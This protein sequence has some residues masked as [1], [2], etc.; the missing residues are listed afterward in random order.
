MLARRV[1]AQ[2]SASTGEWYTPPE[3]IELVREALGGID[4]DPCSSARANTIVKATAIYTAAD[5]PLEVPWHNAHR[6]AFVNP[7]GTCSPGLLFYSGCGNLIITKGGG[8]GRCSCAL[9][10]KFLQKSLVEAGRGMEIV[11]LAYSVNQL[12]QLSKLETPPG[13]TTLIA[14]PPDRI[15]YLDPQTLEPVKGTNCDSAFVYLCDDRAAECHQA[16]RFAITFKRAGCAV[17]ERLP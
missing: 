7:P 13:V 1:N 10:R 6:T 14:L 2:H 4:L 9:P 15:A 8:K 17:Y 12:R 11:Y 3:E 16:E 5:H